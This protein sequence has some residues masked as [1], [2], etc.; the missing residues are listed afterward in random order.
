MTLSFVLRTASGNIGECALT[1]SC[2]FLP[3]SLGFLCFCCWKDNMQC[4]LFFFRFLFCP[5]QWNECL[6]ERCLKDVALFWDKSCKL[7]RK[8]IFPLNTHE[9]RTRRP[10]K[11]PKH[12]NEFLARRRRE[13]FGYIG[14]YTTSNAPQ[15]LTIPS[16]ILPPPP[17]PPGKKNAT[18]VSLI[19]IPPP[20]QKTTTRYKYLN[21]N[22]IKVC[23]KWLMLLVWHWLCKCRYC[24]FLFSTL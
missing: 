4:F 15:A 8:C 2:F 23:W 3:T 11:P 9:G 14:K 19:F 7:P 13:M 24:W 21:H 10:P 1:K 12:F 17:K 5:K 20:P 18:F 22:F 16:K 6:R